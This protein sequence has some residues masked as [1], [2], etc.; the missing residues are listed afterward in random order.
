MTRVL[1]LDIDDTLI[2]AVED[3]AENREEFREKSREFQEKFPGRISYHR[4]G[5][6]EGFSLV[7][8]PY[9]GCFLRR[10]W[11]FYDYVGVWSAGTFNYVHTVCDEIFLDRD[12]DF[13]LTREDCELVDGDFLKRVSRV[14]DIIHWLPKD[15]EMILLDDF[16]GHCRL[17]PETRL[18][19]GYTENLKQG[20]TLD[21]VIEVEDDELLK[22]IMRMVEFEEI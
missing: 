2:R 11:D 10:C 21:R 12:P 8:R 6:G 16:A 13:I 7:K 14:P 15:S 3:P 17:S 18:I 5:I 22:L 19:K 1:I 9:L 20:K 4:L